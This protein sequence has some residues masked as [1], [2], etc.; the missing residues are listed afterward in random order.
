MKAILITIPES[1]LSSQTPK[2]RF[3]KINLQIDI[4]HNQKTDL[5]KEVI[6]LFYFFIPKGNIQRHP[7]SGPLLVGPC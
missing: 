5:T 4:W 6:N 2:E 7:L 1:K 3:L